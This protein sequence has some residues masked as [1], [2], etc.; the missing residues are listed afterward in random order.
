MEKSIGNQ[1]KCACWN[2]LNFKWHA[3]C[4]TAQFCWIHCTSCAYASLNCIQS[5]ADPTWILWLWCGS[6]CK[7]VGAN[8]ILVYVVWPLHVVQDVCIMWTSSCIII[9]PF[10]R[11]CS[12]QHPWEIYHYIKWPVMYLGLFNKH[13]ARLVRQNVLKF[14][15]AV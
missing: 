2:M 3:V 12:D 8:L 4:S 11:G 9:A 15:P 5:V 10:L 7:N 1:K 6:Q 14:H 13:E